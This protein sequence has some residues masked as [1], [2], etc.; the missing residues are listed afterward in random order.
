MKN[1]LRHIV[2]LLL[3]A[4][5]A[6]GPVNARADE[7]VPGELIIG[8]HAGARA[9]ERAA[10]IE[11]GRAHVLHRFH[12]IDAAW[13]RVDGD[14]DS[15]MAVLA[16]DPRVAYVEPNRIWHADVVPDDPLFGEQWALLNTGQAGGTTGA[17]IEAVPAWDLFTGVQDLR[18]GIID[19]GIDLTHP[20]LVDNL[21]TNPGEIPGNGVDDDGN[22]YVDDVHGYDF[23]N[24]DPDPNDDFGHGTHV[25]GILA[26]RTGNGIGIAGVAWR[27][28]LVAIKFLDSSGRG[29]TS[30]AIEAIEYASTLGLR[31]TSNSWGGSVPSG[32]LEAAIAAAGAAGQ[33]FVA[34]AGNRAADN[35]AAPEYPSSYDLPNIVAVAATGADDRL[36][37]FSNYGLQSVDIAAP[38]VAILSCLPGGAYGRL[39]GTSMA[40]PMV[41]G[42]LAL[43]IG[44]SPQLSPVQAI[45]VLLAGAERIPTLDGLV[46][47]AARLNVLHAVSDPD[48]VAP[49]AIT[50]LAIA[51][52]GS[53]SMTLEWIAT[54]DDGDVGRASDYDIRYATYP[55]DASNLEGAAHLF[56]LV[57]GAPGDTERFEITGL[58]V[59]TAYWFVVRARDEFGNLS[60]LTASVEG[61]TLG[62][63]QIVT[64][65][66]AVEVALAVGAR[67]TA[68]VEIANAAEGTLDFTVPSVALAYP[69]PPAAALRVAT[70]ASLKGEQGTPGPVVAASAGGPDAAGHRWVDSRDPAGPA[71]AWVDVTGDGTRVPL[72]GDDVLSAPIDIGFEFPFYGATVRAVRVSTNGLLT[73]SDVEGAPVNQ[74]LPS[75][76]GPPLT[77]APFWDDLLFASVQRAW[78]RADPDRFIVTWLA[79]PH[80]GSGGPYTFQ[81]ILYANGEIRFQYLTMG[82]A[83]L[84]AT[85]GIQNADRTVGLTV[86]HNTEFFVDSL[87]VRILSLPQ[88]V[89]ASPATGRVHAGEHTE[90]RLAVDARGLKGGTYDGTL[91]IRSN[92]P[93]DSAHAIPIRLVASGA[94]D[95]VLDPP[96]VAFGDVFVG[97]QASATVRV[98]NP[99]TE[100]LQVA[101]IEIPDPGIT[102]EPQVFAVPPDGSAALEWTFRPAVA[103]TLAADAVL[104]SNA[105]AGSA[106]LAL[107]GRAVSPPVLALEPAS[108]AAELEAGAETA[109][110]LR[111]ENRGAAPLVFATRAAAAAAG[112]ASGPWPAA[113][114]MPR[115]KRAADAVAGI[116]GA[117]AGGPDAFGYTFRTGDVPGGPVFEWIDA[118]AGGESLALTGDDAVSAPLPIG[119]DFPFYGAAHGTL[120]VCTNGWLSFTSALTAFS[121]TALPSAAA[122]VPENLVA[123]YWDDFHFA[124]GTHAWI[125]RDPGR[126]VVEWHEAGRL[127]DALRPNTFEAV[128]FAD[129]RIRF[130]Y[131]RMKG[132]N[133]SSGTAGIQ[134]AARDDGLTAAYDVAFVQD[135]LVIEF[136]PPVPWLDVVPGTG[137]IAP[138]AALDLGV[139]FR[140]QNLLAGSFAGAIVISSND[141]LRPMAAAPCTL[142]VAGM[143]R[144]V[145]D[146]EPIV[147]EQAYAGFVRALDVGLRN[148][149]TAAFDAIQVASGDPAL[150]ASLEPAR[151][152]PGGTGTLHLGLAAGQEGPFATTV[153]LTPATGAPATFTVEAQVTPAPRATTSTGRIEATLANGIGEAAAS[154][155]RPVVIANAGGSPLL[156]HADV[157]LG[158]LPVSGRAL[159]APAPGR[160]KGIR[161]AAGAVGAA[162]PDAA[163]YEWVDSRAPGAPPFAWIDVAATGAPVALDQDDQLSAPVA[164]PFPFPFYDGAFDSVRIA[165]N[166]YLTFGDD[167]VSYTN[168]ALPHPDAPHDLIAPFWTDLDFRP[169]AGA[170]RV[171][172]ALVGDRYVIAFLDVPRFGGGAPSSFE[173]LLGADGAIDFQYLAAG[174]GADEATIGIQNERGDVGLTAAWAAP[175]VED[176]MRIS[177]RRR[178]PWLA[179]DRADGV[180]A[181]GARDT[182][183]ARFAAPQY[184]DGAYSG[185]VWLHTSDPAR[186]DR[187]IVAA[188]HVG[189]VAARVSLDPRRGGPG[190]PRWIEARVTPH[191]V[192]DPDALAG[193]RPTLAGVGATGPATPLEDGT[194]L[195][196]FPRLPVLRALPAGPAAVLALAAEVEGLAWVFGAD[197]LRTAGPVD[198]SAPPFP[199]TG[200]EEAALTWRAAPGTSVDAYLTL[201]FGATWNALAR[202]VTDGAARFR[203][204]RVDAAAAWLELEARDAAGYAGSSFI[205]PFAIGAGAPL[206]ARFALRVDG[207]QPAR[208]PVTF[209]LALPEDAGVRVDVFDLRGARVA[210]LARG[211]MPAGRTALVWDG[212]DRAGG[213]AAPGLYFARALAGSR[214]VRARIVLIR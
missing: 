83:T 18:V 165:S 169:Q 142:R 210:T 90:L 63:P 183:W 31:L 81:A 137:T 4:L 206:P 26:A 158:G 187:I 84:S 117:A 68:T 107:S 13:L 186:P 89:S 28:Q 133:L 160:P 209:Q 23:A 134:N 161:A 213:A 61:V 100:W 118:T 50:G 35:D 67:D 177:F 211:F 195:F 9:A 141:P 174:A 198:V 207:A 151:I 200:G 128:L 132:E 11:R 58:D 189:T 192:L 103:G 40:T 105:G 2:P 91:T 180:V 73:F 51:E 85:A 93:A 22:G 80:Y 116:G 194:V 75:T 32:A 159:A 54:G 46:H 182:L 59:R 37:P 52:S 131:L 124:G 79:V 30:A 5:A 149:G 112:P 168:V 82:A 127:D 77:I 197:T 173:V 204:P 150:S 78:Y 162:G 208:A 21:W 122:G 155:E 136:A 176:G 87:A 146:V 69:P 97:A 74:F 190:T 108:L 178:Q 191:A 125:R 92:D 148:A 70:D 15:A 1:A 72:T 196:R 170:A 56:G 167:P 145:A 49:G 55:L 181:P 130:Q 139:T 110:S 193:A 113:A 156:W 12:T 104:H 29:T 109:R 27:A 62:P 99:G 44:R 57:P 36:A 39:S 3:L 143:A 7:R 41:A 205:G 121:N 199:L 171:R 152:A 166:G 214:E 212:R 129:G 48:T 140:T 45:D 96:G 20:D 86:A 17:D 138:G 101:G 66:S 19:S 42:A 24:H 65:P 33:V 147:V 163:G 25:A 8:W 47:D 94:P 6:T 16:A 38:G 144:L 201:D 114:S 164:L 153:T 43:L 53:N 185:A 95:L 135:S 202:G 154:G 106:L 88:W 60:P 10:L 115:A 203:V 14:P 179:L 71:F 175:L 98:R 126:T 172:T 119:F 120:R 184:G 76:G 111:L 157:L 102:V 123:P 188:M 34:A 64:T